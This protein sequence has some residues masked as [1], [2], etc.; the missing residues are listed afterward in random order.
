[1]VIAEFAVGVYFVCGFYSLRKIS[2]TMWMA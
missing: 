1:M 2:Q